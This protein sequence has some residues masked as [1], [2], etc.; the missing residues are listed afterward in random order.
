MAD[1][2]EVRKDWV[3]NSDKERKIMEEKMGGKMRLKLRK[4]H[5]GR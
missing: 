2:L 5:F 4:K 3:K 1:E